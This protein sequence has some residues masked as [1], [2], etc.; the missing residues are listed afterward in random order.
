MQRVRVC[1]VHLP[2][3]HSIEHNNCQQCRVVCGVTWKVNWQL[4][5]IM[6]L[7]C[8]SV[9]VCQETNR[10]PHAN[11]LAVLLND[12]VS[13]QIPFFA[14]L[15]PHSTPQPDAILHFR[16]HSSVYVCVFGCLLLNGWV[17]ISLILDI[18]WNMVVPN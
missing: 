17:S 10:C 9:C 6:H 7:L 4:E 15:F 8:Q 13:I 18:F 11:E 14:C 2:D 16:W 3:F 5:F 1:Y 12:C